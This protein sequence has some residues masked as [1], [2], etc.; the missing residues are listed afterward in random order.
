MSFRKEKK[1]RLTI[2]EFDCLKKQLLE[3][4]MFRLYEKRRVNSLYYDTKFQ[5]MFYHSEEGVLPRK[6]VRIR[7]Y[8]LD[9][10]YNIENKISSIEGRH[11]TTIA[12]TKNVSRRFPRTLS[13]QLYGLLTPSL[14]VC[15]ERDYYSIGGV[16]VTFDS[17][18]KYQNFRHSK[19]KEFEDPERVMEIKVGINISDDFIENLIPYAT[20]RF[21]KYSRGLLISQGQN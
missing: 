18:I 15:Y 16:R 7:W 3:H 19:A 5:D 6:K 20:T 10:N 8:D 17:S 13:D 14:L 12:I 11:K 4:G 9:N 1:Y 21:S 2:F